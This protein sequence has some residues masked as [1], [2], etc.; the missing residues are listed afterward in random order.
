MMPLNVWPDSIYDNT[1]TLPE[2]VLPLLSCDYGNS[3]IAS[4][5]LWDTYSC[6]SQFIITHFKKIF[7]CMWSIFFLQCYAAFLV[8]CVANGPAGC[9]FV[10]AT[11]HAEMGHLGLL[12]P[13]V[14]GSLLQYGNTQLFWYLLCPVEGV[15]ENNFILKLHFGSVSKY[16]RS[17]CILHL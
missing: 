3:Y 15:P 16:E 1:K 5:V 8:A 7:C 12:N 13:H 4:L 10:L 9:F 11:H 14:L 6:L 17:H 2:I